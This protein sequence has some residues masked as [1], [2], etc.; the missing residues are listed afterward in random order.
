[1]DGAIMSSGK[2]LEQ[3]REQLNK[4]PKWQS[5]I[6]EA[7]KLTRKTTTLE[8]SD[9]HKFRIQLEALRRRRR[10]RG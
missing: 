5:L 2:K 1:M 9:L 3:L 4:D 10:I 7:E 8:M 6:S